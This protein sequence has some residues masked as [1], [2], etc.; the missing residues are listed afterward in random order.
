MSV[1]GKSPSQKIDELAEK[2][3]Q[4]D[5][6]FE[7]HRALT[8]LRLQTLEAT[9]EEQARSEGELK[10]KVA[11]LN[12]R[13][14]TLEERSRNQE[15]RSDRGFNFAQAA[16]ISVVSMVGGAL[17]SLLVQLAIKK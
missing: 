4:L 10:N 5:V 3:R 8:D 6:A 14:A 9:S 7:R 1:P 17:L 2:L 13:N 12:A 11:E 16:I 15:K